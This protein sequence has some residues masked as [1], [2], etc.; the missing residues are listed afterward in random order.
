[1]RND[2]FSHLQNATLTKEEF[3]QLLYLPRRE[4]N[5]SA[6]KRFSKFYTNLDF[7]H[8]DFKKRVKINTQLASLIP[9][10]QFI[11][12]PEIK[13]IELG[14]SFG[15]ISSIAVAVYL[16]RRGYKDKISFT[17]LDMCIEPLENTKIIDFDLNNLLKYFK[18]TRYLEQITQILR[19]SQIIEGSL[20]NPHGVLFKKF[21]IVISA[22]T[23]HHLNIRDKEKA[24]KVMEFIIQTGG[25][26]LLGD[27]TFT[28]KQYLK[29][30]E[31]HSMEKNSKGQNIPYA[32]ESFITLHDHSRMFSKSTK[33]MD[34]HG[35][36]YYCLAFKRN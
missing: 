2:I 7:T 24:C 3:D 15:T 16:L 30:L 1:M 11:H 29:W 19:N 31:R 20:I 6:K 14:A 12:Y 28:Y 35:D 26:I 27:L 9:V 13:I 21:N 5:N 8:P 32:V 18:A 33:I 34:L 25:L 10:N 4:F 17:L 36:I 22:F 23:Q